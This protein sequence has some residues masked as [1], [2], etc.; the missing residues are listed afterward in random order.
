M[1]PPFDEFYMIN[2]VR[3]ILHNNLKLS[4]SHKI[5]DF[6]SDLT[7]VISVI[8]IC[9]AHVIIIV[10]FDRE[11]LSQRRRTE[12]TTVVKLPTYDAVICIT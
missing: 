1:F 12:R 7:T 10:M 6:V 2:H 8:I 3:G 11:T 5:I 4:L 9:C